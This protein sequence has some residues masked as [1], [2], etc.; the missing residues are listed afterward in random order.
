MSLKNTFRVT[1]TMDELLQEGGLDHGMIIDMVEQSVEG[2]RASVDAVPLSMT[3]RDDDILRTGVLII[4]GT[5]YG[6][7]V[8]REIEDETV[9]V[10]VQVE[11]IGWRAK[12]SANMLDEI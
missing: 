8:Q 12:N 2:R 6:F 3:G 1:A 11:E 4:D 10:I 9:K 5:E 7:Q